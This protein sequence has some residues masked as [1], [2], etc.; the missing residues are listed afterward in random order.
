[1]DTLY[2]VS[3]NRLDTLRAF[4]YR[5]DSDVNEILKIPQI[6]TSEKEKSD[7]CRPVENSAKVGDL[8]GIPDPVLEKSGFEGNSD[9]VLVKSGVEGNPVSV[10]S[11]FEDPELAAGG[12][13]GKSE[14]V[15]VVRPFYVEL[16]EKEKTHF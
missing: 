13:R 9:P 8:S 16:S 12:T 7:F 3:A 15:E 11:G 5:F 4:S 2:L 1:M 14:V 6:S 10:K